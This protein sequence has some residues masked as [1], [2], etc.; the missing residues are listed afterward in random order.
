MR[1]FQNFW[2]FILQGGLFH[3]QKKS[4]VNYYLCTLLYFFLVMANILSLSTRLK[5]K[6][7]F[8]LWYF[9]VCEADT[10]W[11]I[12]T[13]TI[14]NEIDS[15]IPLAGENKIFLP[16]SNLS[17]FQPIFPK[18]WSESKSSL[19]TCQLQTIEFIAG[20]KNCGVEQ[21]LSN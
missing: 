10:I 18:Y 12:R 2:A 4:F 7:M 5:R 20:W 19:G 15:C 11:N 8:S 9:F 21:G 1:N 14:K 6:I 17:V 16:N 3:P 13:Q